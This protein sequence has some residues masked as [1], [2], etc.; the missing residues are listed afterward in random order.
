M[1][2]TQKIFSG[3]HEVI[4]VLGIFA[5]TPTQIRQVACP[6]PS[7]RPAHRRMAYDRI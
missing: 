2:G 1:V 5:S 4:P 7:T 6:P 3:E